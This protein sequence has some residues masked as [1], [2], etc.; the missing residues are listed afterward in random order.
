M[1]KRG[2]FWT[3]VILLGMP[4]AALAEDVRVLE[5]RP[6]YGETV[7]TIPHEQCREERIP[8]H[9]GTN[10]SGQLFGGLIGG[11]AGSQFG[12]GRGRQAATVAGALYGS[13]LG[14]QHIGARPS[15]VQ[16]RCNTVEVATSRTE[17]LGYDVI[18]EQNGRLWRTR[19]PEDPGPT[20]RMPPRQSDLHSR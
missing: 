11:Y 4:L 7:S 12:S 10:R 3:L 1:R 15:Q 18:Y 5:A 9:A 17:I 20:M 16:V 14:R 6:Y 19:L 8:G 13:E 2:K